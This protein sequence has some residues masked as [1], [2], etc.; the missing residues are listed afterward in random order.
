MPDL[1][2]TLVTAPPA[3][4]NSASKLLVL[5]A[6]VSR[7]SADGISTVNSP[8]RW[9][10]SMPSIWTLLPRRLCP[11]ILLSSE[12]CELKNSECGRLGRVAPGTVAHMPWKL[13]PKP[14]GIA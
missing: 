7:A 3:R 11:F 1:S 2:V 8:V 12:S 4:P 13:R 14:S 5:T 6:T 9:L 10:L